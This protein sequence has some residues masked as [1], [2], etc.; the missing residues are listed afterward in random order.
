MSKPQSA[1]VLVT[2]ATGFV[3]KVVLEELLRR[4]EE[5]GVARVAVLIRPK[6]KGDKVTSGAARFRS[7][8]MPAK[9]FEVL[10]ANW[11]EAVDVIDGDLEQPNCGIAADALRD[12]QA[13]LT[14]IIHCAASVEFDLPIADAAK[15]NITSALNVLELARGCTQLVG[16]TSVSTAYV[17]PWRKG[18]I[19]ETL[20]HIPR[21]AAEL[22]AAIVEGTRTE[23]D[24]LKE[25][26][27]PNT[28][29]YTK[30]L[31]E[32]LLTE[33][34]GSV[35]LAIVRPSIIAGAWKYPMQ[36]W[37]DSTAAFTGCLMFLGMGMVKAWAADPSA[38]A[39]VVPVDVV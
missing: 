10:P 30:C 17:T 24:L 3:G 27:H 6:T 12:V 28:Y 1:Y 37:I 16:M 2:G 22:H 32:H 21:P 23:A 25:S 5:L 34:R 20:A 33:R 29:T 8:V 35:P 11:H 4:K 9:L 18:P 14:H 15:A 39:D 31:A 7:A 13:K 26:G 19:T 38:R 36:G